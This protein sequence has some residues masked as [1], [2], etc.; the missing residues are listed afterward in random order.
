[1]SIR[2]G[3]HAISGREDYEDLSI[4]P[5]VFIREF[6]ELLESMPTSQSLELLK[7]DGIKIESLPEFIEKLNIL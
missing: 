2:N 6:K 7:I 5:T 4:R 3:F 1:M